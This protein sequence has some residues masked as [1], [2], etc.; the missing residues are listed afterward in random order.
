L[1]GKAL[2]AHNRRMDEEPPPQRARIRAP[3]HLWL[4]GVLL[5][6]WNAW[7]LAIALAAQSGQFFGDVPEGT[8]AYFATQP[9]WFVLIADIGPFAGVAGA[10]ALLL[11]HRLASR[12]FA[13]QLIVIVLSNGYELAVG[14]SLL[15]RDPTALWG[16]LFLLPLLAGQ[17]LYARHLQRK[18]VLY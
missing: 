2:Q 6:L 10:V 9:L 11:Q 17:I 12:L 14:R 1:P 8:E 5:V 18:G 13:L 7:G 15:P 4:V 3:V 16:T